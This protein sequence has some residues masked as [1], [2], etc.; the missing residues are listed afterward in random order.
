MRAPL[1]DLDGRRFDVAVIGG[2]VNGS[3]AAQHL[4][5][6]GY[7]VLLVDKGDFASGSSS[8][9][10]R[11]LHCGL[12]YLA[13]GASMW[14]FVRH[15][16]RL[17]T[18]L[19]M[20]RQGMTS[21]TRFVEA[22]PERIEAFTA[23]FPIYDDLPYRPWQLD[24][25]FAVLRG[26]DPGGT[27][28]DY[29]R[30][31][32]DRARKTPL[33]SWLRDF[34]RLRSIVRFREYRFEWPER[35]VID[36]VLDARRLGA[37]ARNYTAV[38]AMGR[39][40]DGWAITLEDTQGESGQAAVRA[41]VVL[42]MAGIWIDRINRMADAKAGRKI[43]GTKGIHIMVRLPPECRS[44]GIIGLN[45]LNEPFYCAPLARTPLLR[46]HRDP[47]RGRHR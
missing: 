41:P 34:D 9:S 3:A 10:T 22:T 14:E 31:A 39:D 15:P 35:I 19:R 6:A 5:A 21:R 18:A 40:G 32:L 27:P 47:V 25:A 26:L 30:L 46:P 28:L 13:P 7:S 23:H 17:L 24:L 1:A 11:L 36:T 8:R 33:V 38:A 12:R 4:A 37:V 16:G 42:N 29:G 44:H 43:T 2:G 45:R 20:A